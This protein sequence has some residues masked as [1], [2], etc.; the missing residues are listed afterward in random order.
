M[1]SQIHMMWRDNGTNIT[2]VTT[3][4]ITVDVRYDV[5]L[6]SLDMNYSLA[7]QAYVRDVK[8]YTSITYYLNLVCIPLLV[9]IGVIGNGLSFVVFLCTH[10][11]YQS[12]SIYLAFLNLADS[13]FLLNVFLSVWLGYVDVHVTHKE[14]GC[15]FIIYISYVFGFLSVWTVVSFTAE[16]YIVVFY[17]LKKHT[18][19]TPRRAK[20][21]VLGLLAVALLFYLIAPL[22]SVVI[23]GPD[24]GKMMCQPRPG[25]GV[26]W[27]YFLHVDSFVTFV[28]PS[29]A[30]ILLNIRITLKICKF[31]HWNV[32]SCPSKT[33]NG[34]DSERIITHNSRVNEKGQVTVVGNTWHRSKSPSS[35]SSSVERRERL[36]IENQERNVRSG[37][38]WSRNTP[39]Q[40][41][42]TRNGYQLRT[43][44]ALVIVSS[45]FLVLNLPSHVFRLYYSFA[46]ITSNIPA[47]MILWQNILQMFYYGNF[48]VNVFLYSACSRSFRV[49]L[50]R[51]LNRWNRK[52]RNIFFR[53]GCCVEQISGPGS[54]QQP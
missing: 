39:L 29:A 44:R 30:I 8:Y 14:G 16:R 36:V 49:A 45:V 24:N 1:T 52:A 51:L 50:Q 21:I 18:L 15:Q 40:Y 53:A 5:G 43:T 6:S 33:L 47:S 2:T 13:G 10:L 48:S 46:D 25:F 3:A 54:E 4:A 28:I 7:M 9:V 34:R 20:A 17:P 27:Y 22:T 41:S 32:P 38:D 12:S 42:S 31:V 23:P 37:Q 11:R 26:F 35:T 19:C